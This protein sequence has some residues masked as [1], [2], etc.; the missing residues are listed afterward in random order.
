MI[1]KLVAFDF[2][3][4]LMNSPSPEEG[5]VL[6]KE[7]TGKDFPDKGWWS[8]PAS[9]DID[10][11]DI[12]PYNDIANILA[13]EGA[14]PNTMVI[15]LT[16]RIEALR[17]DL[18]KVLNKNGIE[19]DGIFMN[20]HNVDKG[21]RIYDFLRWERNIKAIDVYDD[22]GK[23]I[24]AYF[25]IKKHMPEDIVFNIYRA[26]KGSVNLLENQINIKKIINEE[27]DKLVWVN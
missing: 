1:T 22:R 13:K 7:R 25:L 3:G 10:V 5:M 15:I 11:F 27:I 23:D 8:S 26:D 19:V 24:E 17:P 21:E 16:S 18:I 20:D 6:Y 14:N 9:L 2:D 12:K 4:T